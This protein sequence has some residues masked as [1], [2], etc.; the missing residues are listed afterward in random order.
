M[1]AQ[2]FP[3]LPV[4]IIDDEEDILQSYK[5]T[6]RL[7]KID[8]FTLCSDPRQVMDM[9]RKT[10]Y[11]SI[12][13]DLFMPHMSGQELLDRIHE[14][15]PE[16]PI[17][18]ATGSNSVT[19]A[20]EC[21][22]RGAFDYMVKPV[23]VSRFISGLMNA[24]EMGELRYENTALKKQVLGGKLERPEAFSKIITVSDSIRSI[25]GYIE[26]IASSSK[27]VLITGESG[28]GKELFTRAIHDVSGRAG[29]FIA[30]NVAGLD[31]TVFSDTLFGHRKGAYTGADADRAGLVEQA[32]GGTL[33]LDEIGS[34]EMGSQT[35]L[36]RLLQEGEYYQL[37]SDICKTVNT[38]V[39]AATNEDLQVRMKEGKF[40]SDLYFRL[41]IHHIHIPPLRQ[42]P[43]D[44]C[45]LSEHFASIAAHELGRKT[46]SMPAG[47]LPTLN[48]YHF[49]G[50]VRELQSL[51][52]DTVSRSSAETFD[53]AYVK[54]YCS[55]ASARSEMPEFWGEGAPISFTGEI[56]K[57]K[58][59]EEYLIAQAIKMAEGN[60]TIAAQFLGISQSTLSRRL[61]KEQ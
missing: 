29:K 32:Q 18:V 54:E 11:S 9:L 59:V 41:K 42:R 53:D 1:N 49:P 46:P 43:E 10:A 35:K 8:N 51:M 34:L 45:V 40:R 27:P 23:E 61:R 39:I 37:G 56:P 20:V 12:I 5:M 15:H 58:D 50:N 16:I 24:I 2:K 52:F 17:I 33:F 6:L 48:Q 25:F 30:V 26:A 57:L 36:L 55:K 7:R 14:K 21:M 13:L 19:T 60:Q 4:L 44:I 22:K 47:I 3:R 28:T 31:D 38:A